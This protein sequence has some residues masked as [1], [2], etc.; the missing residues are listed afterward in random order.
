LPGTKY[1]DNP[2]LLASAISAR[3][4]NSLSGDAFDKE[5]VPA[6]TKAH[7]DAVTLFKDYAT[8]GQSGSVRDF[9]AKTLPTL[10]MHYQMVQKLP[11]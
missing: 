6:Q 5:Y 4:L 7:A 11:R 8:T 10:Q 9:A 2:D 3:R 1:V